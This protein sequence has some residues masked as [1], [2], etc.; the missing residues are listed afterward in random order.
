[1]A[2]H[3]WKTHG[4]VSRIHLHPT[5]LI[6]YPFDMARPISEDTIR[7]SKKIEKL[8]AR[9]KG[10]TRGEA[11]ERLE[12]SVGQWNRAKA[13]AKLTQRGTTKDCV[14]FARKR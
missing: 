3:A 6:V 11:M 10:V 13:L 2:E 5:W 4:A 8:A 1:M 7:N 12:L 9:S 14:Y